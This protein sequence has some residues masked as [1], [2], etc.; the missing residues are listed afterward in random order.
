[1]K[2]FFKQRI[3]PVN[4]P[5]KD[6]FYDGVLEIEH[7]MTE[8]M[9]VLD[10]ANVFIWEAA[11]LLAN[12]IDL[13]EMGYFDAAFYSLRQSIEV[14]TTMMFLADTKDITKKKE[15]FSAWKHEERFP[16]T[17]QML[18]RLKI[19]GDVVANMHKVM[20][21]F[22]EDLNTLYA[23]LN[24]IV[25]KQGYDYLFV[26][27]SLPF[28][29][30]RKDLIPIFEDFFSKAIGVVAVMRL[31]I[32]PIPILVKDD[33]I[34]N[35][36]FAT[37][38]QGFSDKFIDKFVGQEFIA[39]YKRTDIYTNHYADIMLLEKRFPETTDVVQ[40]QYVNTQKLNR[41]LSQLHLLSPKDIPVIKLFAANP[42]FCKAYSYDGLKMFFS[43]KKTARSSQV[44]DSRSFQCFKNS[45]SKYNQPYDE[46]FISVFFVDGEFYYMEHNEKLTNAEIKTLLHIM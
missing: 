41:I 12:S 34:F 28:S 5:D 25:H 38:N 10:I 44:F 40:C 45:Q 18:A 13:F 15:A 17:K 37:I 39:Q 43:D 1:M 30:K 14:A 21:A 29:Q 16:M 23:A 46:V 35:R 20:P 33:E 6:E 8:R 2:Q 42:K 19:Y 4:L 31:A 7:S 9:D 24:K 3:S 22:F 11:Q 32:D 26:T 27:R 36:I